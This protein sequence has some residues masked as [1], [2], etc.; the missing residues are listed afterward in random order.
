MLSDHTSSEKLPAISIIPAGTRGPAEPHW[1]VGLK[2]ALQIG[3]LLRSDAIMWQRPTTDG[4]MKTGRDDQ[5]RSLI[6]RRPRK[7]H[8]S[9]SA[10]HPGL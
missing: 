4:R 2:P 10:V 7:G 9:L 1:A 5:P 6:P 3:S 8:L